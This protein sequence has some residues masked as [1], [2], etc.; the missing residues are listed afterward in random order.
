MQ[1][2]TSES[3]KPHVQQSVMTPVDQYVLQQ[4][5]DF[6]AS[7][8][9]KQLSQYKESYSPMANNTETG[10]LLS[11]EQQNL[12]QF[13]HTSQITL[14]FQSKGS[15]HQ[16]LRDLLQNK[17]VSESEL[18]LTQENQVL[19]SEH[20]SQE[21]INSS[22]TLKLNEVVHDPSIET[23]SSSGKL[24]L[25]DNLQD[26][27]I[28]TSNTSGKLKLSDVLNDSSVEIPSSGKVTL[29]AVLED[30]EIGVANTDQVFSPQQSCE[31]IDV[32]SSSSSQNNVVS[33]ILNQN[34]EKKR[35][36]TAGDLLNDLETQHHDD[37][38]VA[39]CNLDVLADVGELELD[40]DELLGLGNDFNI[41]EYADPEL[42]K[43]LVGEG[44]KSNIL[45]EHLDLDDKDEELEDDVIKDVETQDKDLITQEI[46]GEKKSIH[47][48][49]QKTD[50]D[51]NQAKASHMHESFLDFDKKI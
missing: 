45:D 32:L 33:K 7:N 31:K 5:S 34:L 42:D 27:P 49:D 35:K 20:S 18:P 2:G 6:P 28:E 21:L 48:E 14:P 13:L 46:S 11:Q 39:G 29:S 22:E 40:D 44:E 38:I 50:S 47:I 36:T 15:P 43:N 8:I 19:T 51:I 10:Q 3:P 4:A 37:A 30:P 17:K 23:S 25:S 26:S 1:T 41:L 9:V 24:K 12:E 16:H